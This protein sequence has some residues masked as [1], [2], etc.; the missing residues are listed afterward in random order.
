MA[1]WTGR[2]QAILLR[3]WLW[4]VVVCLSLLLTICGGGWGTIRWQS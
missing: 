4:P 3:A 2:M 1:A